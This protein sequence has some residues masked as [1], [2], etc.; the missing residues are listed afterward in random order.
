MREATTLDA[1]SAVEHRP[2]D[3]VP[4]RLVLKDELADRLRKLVT[5]PSAL[6]SPRGLALGG[7]NTCC[8][9][10]EGGCAELVRR[11][12]RDGSRLAG[13][14][15]SMPRCATQV[16]RRAHG[17]GT[18]RTRLH[19][20]DLAPHPS[21]DLLDRPARSWVVGLSRLE[22]VKGLPRARGSPRSEEM[23]VRVGRHSR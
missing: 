4:P 21:T 15:R 10:R 6:E 2:A 3:L 11:D 9:D 1:G 8:L 7:G 13:G 18:R 17:M 16:P 19:H 5:L 20:R 12:V 23:I 22:V 14:V